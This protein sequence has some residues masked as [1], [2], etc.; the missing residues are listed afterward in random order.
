M[1]RYLAS[2][3]VA[4]NPCQKIGQP[5]SREN[6]PPISNPAR[7][8]NVAHRKHRRRCDHR[9]INIPAFRTPNQ[10]IVS[11]SNLRRNPEALFCPRLKV[12]VRKLGELAPLKLLPI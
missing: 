2:F 4:D 1:A 11:V 6:Y 12:G 8:N 9:A 7:T 3:L 10:S 5:V